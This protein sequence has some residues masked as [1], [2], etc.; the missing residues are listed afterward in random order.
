[1]NLFFD[2]SA[3]VKL[4]HEEQ[5]S[6]RVTQLITSRENQIWVSDLVRVEFVSALSRRF[7]NNEIDDARLDQALSGFEQQLVAFKVEPLGHSSIREAEALLKQYGKVYG[8]R[9]LDALH[10]GVF[11]L[12][13]D[14]DWFFVAADQK[15]CE[16]S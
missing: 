4:F 16:V 7:R 14:K 12:I 6:R 9:T 2:T 10:L 1:M 8:L 13:S 15:L 5:W 3:L 11:S